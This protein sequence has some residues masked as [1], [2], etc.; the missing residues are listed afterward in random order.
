MTG[1]GPGEVCDKKQF[2][3]SLIACLQES[4]SAFAKLLLDRGVNVLLADLVLRPEAQELVEAHLKGSPQA[5][6][7][8]IDVTSWSDLSRMFEVAHEKFD[9][10]DIVCREAGIFEPPSSNF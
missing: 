6:Y 3:K 10:I 9:G 8:K 1:A 4:T 2:S 7:L 5:A